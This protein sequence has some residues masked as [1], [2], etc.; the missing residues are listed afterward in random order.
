MAEKGIFNEIREALDEV[1]SGRRYLISVVEKL[2]KGLPDIA[3]QIDKLNS[4]VDA[5]SGLSTTASQLSSALEK[6]EGT[7]GIVNTLGSSVQSMKN[8]L[9][10]LSTNIMQLRP[11]LDSVRDY[12]QRQENGL[13]GIAQSLQGLMGTLGEILAKLG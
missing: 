12:A 10:N 1:M 6:L 8:D 4:S 9:G 7:M 3:P 5:I 13:R 11:I 2:R